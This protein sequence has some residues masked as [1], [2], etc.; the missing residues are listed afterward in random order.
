MPGCSGLEILKFVRDMP[1]DI[2]VVLMTAFG[3]TT[4]HQEA[5]QLGA[6]ATLDKPFDAV[7]LRNAVLGALLPSR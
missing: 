2:P 5:R 3:D 4:I 1:F 7:D 6:A